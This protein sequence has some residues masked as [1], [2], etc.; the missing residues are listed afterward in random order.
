MS[1]IIFNGVEMKKGETDKE[2]IKRV[3]EKMELNDLTISPQDST[4][5]S[6][7]TETETDTSDDEKEQKHEFKF[8][9]KCMLGTYDCNMEE[10]DDAV[11]WFNNKYGS[12]ERGSN[13]SKGHY[14]THGDTPYNLFELPKLKSLYDRDIKAV[15][16]YNVKIHIN[17]LKCDDDE[18][19]AYNE[20]EK[21]E[22]QEF[23]NTLN[24]FKRQRDEDRFIEI[25]KCGEFMRLMNRPEIEL[26]RDYEH[27]KSTHKHIFKVGDVVFYNDCE[28]FNYVH[29]WQIIKITPQ[30]IK[31]KPLKPILTIKHISTENNKA[32]V[33][34]YKK[35]D[36]INNI[37]SVYVNKN[38]HN[39]VYEIDDYIYRLYKDG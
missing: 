32:N 33:Y 23:K 24:N 37:K 15:Y 18:D 22:E 1:G 12:K 19:E 4:D 31:I 7:E 35:D 16:I 14:F 21:K 10:H 11:R 25:R 13:G 5:D 39:T 29:F 2:Y 9:F 8:Y 27:S 38:S 36:F 26:K 20:E 6:T 34:K 28:Y 30:K 3:F 17:F